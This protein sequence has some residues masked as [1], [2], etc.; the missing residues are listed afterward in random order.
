[1]Y[2]ELSIIAVLACCCGLVYLKGK[3]HQNL[4]KRVEIIEHRNDKLSY[5]LEY[6]SKMLDLVRD[7]SAREIE[8]LE[9]KNVERVA[10][11]EVR[12]ASF[13]RKLN[14]FKA[15]LSDLLLKKT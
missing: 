4:I 12:Y 1:M 11:L 10:N 2:I 8:L 15:K 13:E 6:F 7:N 9:S 14:E 5:D 3:W